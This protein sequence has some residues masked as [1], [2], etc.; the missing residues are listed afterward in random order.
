[1]IRCLLVLLSCL[2]I[3]A[4]G[5]A[6]DQR[7]TSLTITLWPGGEA[8][9]APRTATLTCQPDGGSLP[10]PAAA[11]AVLTGAGKPALAAVAADAMCTELYGGPEQARITGTLASEP[12]EARLSR[13]NGCELA[14]W[15]AL[16]AVLP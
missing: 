1:M 7:G 14:R 5:G 4:C 6:E 12:V 10:N 8:A 3:V 13:T 9:G 2:A 11:C 15:E 16:S